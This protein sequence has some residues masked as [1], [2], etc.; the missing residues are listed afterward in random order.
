MLRCPRAYRFVR[1][2]EPGWSHNASQGAEARRTVGGE[3]YSEPS[4]KHLVLKCLNP[5]TETTFAGSSGRPTFC[6]KVICQG[7]PYTRLSVAPAAH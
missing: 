2:R 3:T 1:G 6:L 4:P 5:R 7:L